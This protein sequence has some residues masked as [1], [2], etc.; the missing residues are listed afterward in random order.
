V[1]PVN[2]GNRPVVG[3]VG[4]GG[5]S[6]KHLPHL[7]TLGAEVLVYALDGAD[8]LVRRYGGKTVSSLDEL[9]GSA[10]I[11]DVVTPTFA[12]YEVISQA[13]AAGKHVITE[14]PLAR[15]DEQVA[16]LLRDAGGRLHTAH[17]VRYFP[18]YARL[19]A[20]VEAG[21]AG[22]LAV[23][24]FFRSGAYPVRGAWFGDTERSGGIILDQMIH[25]LDIARW[26]AG[27]VVR[28]SATHARRGTPDAPVEAAHVLLTHASGAISHVAGVWGP[29]HLAFTT[30]YSVAGTGGVLEYNSAAESGYRADLGTGQP[31]GGQPGGG[32]PSGGELMPPTDP[33][34]DPY[35][36]VLEDLMNAIRHGTPARLTAADAAAAVRIGNAAIRSSQT[37][38]PVEMG[39]G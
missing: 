20:A 37:G 9:I 39:E 35:F 15:T 3:L 38:Q 34:E 29:V 1:A 32:R 30:G 18:A 12:H 19:H 22:D 5:I 27:E 33:A 7:L 16:A 10:D 8:D 25:D 24:R 36:L 23:L 21:L 31:G 14:K 11:V 13:L 4:A 28:V 2:E 6:P 17:V 26:V